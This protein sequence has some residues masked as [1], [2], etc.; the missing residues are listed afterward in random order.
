MIRLLL[1]A[2]FLFFIVCMKGRVSVSICI[3]ALR[4][5]LLPLINI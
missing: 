2:F 3:I 5:L 4:A 1:A